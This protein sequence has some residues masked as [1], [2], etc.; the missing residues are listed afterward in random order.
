MELDTKTLGHIVTMAKTLGHIVTMAKITV[1]A[2][3]FG[4][5]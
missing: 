4:W 5:L 1:C 2:K 3:S